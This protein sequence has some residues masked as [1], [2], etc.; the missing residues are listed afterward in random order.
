MTETV[1]QRHCV[2]L[3]VRPICLKLLITTLNSDQISYLLTYTLPEKKK[4]F[5]R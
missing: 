1:A 5:G 4:P 2:T 3:E